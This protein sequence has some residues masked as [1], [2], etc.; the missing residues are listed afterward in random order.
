M[1]A[2]HAHPTV[3]SLIALAFVPF[4]SCAAQ[5]DGSR[6]VAHEDLPA[7]SSP[8]SAEVVV[9]GLAVP[10]ATAFLPRVGCS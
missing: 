3:R 10:W 4:A 5:E 2:I 1:I 6:I 8:L 9:D 7:S